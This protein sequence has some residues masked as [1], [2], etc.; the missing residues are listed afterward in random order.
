V[1]AVSSDR[2]DIGT[3]FGIGT[4]A[5]EGAFNYVYH[6][7]RTYPASRR[8]RPPGFSSQRPGF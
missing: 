8:E 7:H 6:I 2:L 4:I 3:R 5:R 1:I